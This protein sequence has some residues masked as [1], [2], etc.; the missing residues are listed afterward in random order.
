MVEG[1]LS[2]IAKT[3]ALLEQPFIKDSSKTVAEHIKEA[4]A[5]IGE[6]IKIRRFTRYNLGEGLEKKACLPFPTLLDVFGQLLMYAVE[7]SSCRLLRVQQQRL[8]E[9]CARG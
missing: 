8:S 3:L 1:R 9:D 6:N 7:P 2:K 4:V 5:G